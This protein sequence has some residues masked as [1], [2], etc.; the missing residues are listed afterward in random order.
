MKKK[1]ILALMVCLLLFT[2]CSKK[3]EVITY[4]YDYINYLDFKMIGPNSYATID[5]NLK[6]FKS[7]DFESE[8]D[9]I[10][11]KKLMASVKENLII[12]K[13]E[14]LTNGDELQI[15]ISE[16]F[17]TSLANGLSINLGVHTMT[18]S[19]LSDPKALDVFDDKNIVFYGLEDTSNVYYYYPSTSEFTQEMKDN[20]NYSITAD[21]NK[22]EKDKTVL[23]LSLSIK[24]D[25]LSS[26]SDYGSED[27]Y[28]L[29]NGYV[30]VL[31][32]EKTL[33]NIVSEEALEKVEKSTLRTSLEEKIA[34]QGDINGYAFQQVVSVQKTETPFNYYVVALYKNDTREVYIKY[35]VKMAYVNN[36]IV[37]YSF[38]KGSTVE[39]RYATEAF[40][41]CT[42]M[43]SYDVF[44]IIEEPVEEVK[45]ETTENTEEPD[46]IVE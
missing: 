8:T 44:E 26:K 25:L 21:D 39:D 42:L 6:D 43:Y 29:A 2:G 40:D 17:D 14:G 38:T 28:F 15:G 41:N 27:R 31:N 35:D 5:V 22:V 11:I 16:N 46:A 20:F 7:S 19:G 36:Q 12:T 9:F 24:S 33:K 1:I 34:E 30:T 18:V 32:G 45:E 4:T 10:A 37:Y 3:E 23:T 13:T